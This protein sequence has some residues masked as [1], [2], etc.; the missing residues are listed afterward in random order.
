MKF[1]LKQ[2]KIKEVKTIIFVDNDLKIIPAFSLTSLKS[3]AASKTTYY[4]QRNSI[5]NDVVINFCC[6]F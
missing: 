4:S 3:K 2:I 6:R 5:K 1:Y